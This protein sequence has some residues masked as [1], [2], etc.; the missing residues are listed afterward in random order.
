[1]GQPH[2]I[3]DIKVHLLGRTLLASQLVTSITG[4]LYPRIFVCH[5]YGSFTYPHFIKIHFLGRTLLASQL[6]TSI[7]GYLYPRIFVYQGFG[8]TT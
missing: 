4:Y 8:L 2:K 5:G 7:T 6:V 3:L 1:M